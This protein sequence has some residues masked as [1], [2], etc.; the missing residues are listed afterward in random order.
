MDINEIIKNAVAETLKESGLIQQE[1][2]NSKNENNVVNEDVISEAYVTQAGKF[3]LKT[4]L[5]SEKTKKAHQALLEGYIETLNKVSAKIDGVD[6]SAANLNHSEFR[7]LKVDE[8]YNHNAAFLHGLY[9]ENI[10]DLSSQINMDSLSYMKW[11]N[12]VHFL[13]SCMVIASITF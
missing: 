1:I 10:S 3:D 4:E 13:L 2:N 12:G 7:G 5:L 6:K 8:S 11:Q 9:F